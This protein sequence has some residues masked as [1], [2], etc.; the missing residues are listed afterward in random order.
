MMRS[1]TP[2]RDSGGGDATRRNGER[3]RCATQLPAGFDGTA[4]RSAEIPGGRF[5][6]TYEQSRAGMSAISLTPIRLIPLLAFGAA[7]VLRAELKH[8]AEAALRME[9]ASRGLDS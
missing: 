6:I 8:T 7:F 9:L 3:R 5:T 2:V 1:S 4:F